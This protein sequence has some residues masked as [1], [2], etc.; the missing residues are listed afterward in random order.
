M[1]ELALMKPRSISGLCLA[2]LALMSTPLLGQT[3]SS[4]PKLGSKY[5][6]RAAE[7]PATASALRGDAN[8]ECVT[9]IPVDV[10]ATCTQVGYDAS[11]ATQ[12]MDPALCNGFASPEANDLWFSFVAT[13]AVTFIEVEGTL[14]FDPVLEAFS[15]TCGDLTSLACADATFPPDP[16]ANS[17][18]TLIM[19]TEVGSTYYL[20][21]YSYWN[22]VPVDLA[23]A[24]CI[25]E[26]SAAPENDLCS[27]VT[28]EQLDAGA[29]LSFTGDNTGAL[30]T[31]GL[32]AG[33]VWHAFTIS[34]TMDL[35]VDYCGTPG[36]GSA[37]EALYVG[38]PWTAYIPADSMNTSACADGAMTLYFANLCPGTYYYAVRLDAAA[39]GEYMLN[40]AGSASIIAYCAAGAERCDEYIAHVTI[41]S[42]DNMSECA[43]GPAVDYTAQSTDIEQGESVSITV[44]NGPTIY[45]EDAVT[46][47]VDW[48]QD[49]TFCQA[50]EAFVLVND[51]T[52]ASFTGTITAPVD[53]PIGTTR[54]RVRMAYNES[55]RACG[56]AEWGEV[57]DYS[58]N[59]TTFMGLRDLDTAEWSVFPNP[60]NGRMTIRFEGS[61]TNALVELFDATGR[62]VFQEQRRLTNGEHSEIDLGGTVAG[63]M[64]TIRVSTPG[65]RSEQGIVIQ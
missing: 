37:F 34:E 14:T 8:D 52:G 13:T 33:S 58:V 38:C 61:N 41:G 55:P 6:V 40:V 19:G 24:L 36:F 16:P 27:A 23:F 60:N 64:Y 9:A 46:V 57:E 18:E 65:S 35:T 28:P 12:S 15:G 47:W 1:Y 7:A 59:V 2:L 48:D 53:A 11:V 30:D 10:T 45:D 25:H 4:A 62:T 5:A 21:V 51:G 17:L 39:E 63:G 31:E 42:I 3:R 56:F 26:G 50:N 49:G 29:S 20:R 32:G 22:P 43:D 54:M 44:L